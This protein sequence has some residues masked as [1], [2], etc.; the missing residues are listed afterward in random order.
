MKKLLAVGVAIAASL[1]YAQES[2]AQTY[3]GVHKHTDT[4]A[5]KTYIYVMGANPGQP[6]T[7]FQ[8]QTEATR[9]ITMNNC[10]WGS[11]TQSATSPVVSV[12]GQTPTNGTAPTC[13]KDPSP[14]TT[15]TTSNNAAPGT[16]LFDGAKIWV[17]GTAN[18]PLAAT[19]ITNR[20]ITT[21]ANACGFV[22]V[23]TSTSRPMTNFS[24]NG[25]NYQLASLSSVNYPAICRKVGTENK[26]YIPMANN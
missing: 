9:N 7:G 3:N 6:I 5:Q 20:A 17:R 4:A 19:V 1:G 23:T 2:K 22:R 25:F 16:V 18:T 15:Y 10:G 13:T 14:A 8:T 11:F 12:N 26:I 24:L 21:K